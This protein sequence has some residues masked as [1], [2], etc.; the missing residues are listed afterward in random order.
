MDERERAFASSGEWFVLAHGSE[1]LLFVT[2]MSENLRRAITLSLVYRDDASRPNP[3]EDVPGTVPLVGYR[4]RGI[5]KLPG[6]RYEFALRI[7]TLPGYRRGDERRLLAQ[8][9][10]PLTAE[11]TAE[12]PRPASEPAARAAAPPAA[13]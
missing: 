12:G 11:L 2:R 4:G 10:A 9:D 3:P 5:E 6:G 1:A 8:L 13:R 7:Y